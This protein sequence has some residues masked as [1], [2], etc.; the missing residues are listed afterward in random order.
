MMWAGIAQ[1]VQRRSTVRT[2]RG[3]NPGGGIIFRNSLD[4][5]WGPTQPPV[6]WVPGTGIMLKNKDTF[7]GIN[8]RDIVVGTMFK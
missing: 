6:Q 2:I 3:S 8:C 4:R 5:P 7:S 1:S